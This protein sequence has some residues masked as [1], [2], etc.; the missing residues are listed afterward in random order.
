MGDHAFWCETLPEKEQLDGWKRH[1]GHYQ[2]ECQRL[3]AVLARQHLLAVTWHGKFA[4]VKQENNRLRQKVARQERLNKE[5]V[6]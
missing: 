5:P 3:R 2:Q 4:I 6:R 1:A